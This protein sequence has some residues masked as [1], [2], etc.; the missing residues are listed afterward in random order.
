MSFLPAIRRASDPLALQAQQ[1]AAVQRRAEGQ[2]FRHGA[3]SWAL[4]E[5]DRIDSEA[6][7]RALGYSFDLEAELLEHV[8]QRSSGQP[9]L[10]ELGGRKVAL[11]SAINNRRIAHRF[12]G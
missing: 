11:A 7:N 6:L 10:V 5:I 1:A 12:G 2:V 9:A 3:D 4:S 8:L